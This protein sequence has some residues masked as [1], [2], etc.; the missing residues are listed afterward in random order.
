MR[1]LTK[2]ILKV[3]T[4]LVALE[5]TVRMGVWSDSAT[6]AAGYEDYRR[7]AIGTVVPRVKPYMDK[8]QLP[9]LNVPKVNCLAYFLT[10]KWNQ[11]V[12]WTFSSLARLPSKT[13]ELANKARTAIAG[14]VDGQTSPPKQ[15]V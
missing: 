15:E 5:T 6:A 11:G 12:I 1:P 13:V 7:S 9:E 14:A 4:A 8:V 10:Q 2:T 3:G